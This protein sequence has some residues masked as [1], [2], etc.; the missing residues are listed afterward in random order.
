ML[1]AMRENASSWIIKILLLAIVVAFVFMGLGSYEAQRASKIATVNEQA[2]SVDDYRETYNNLLQ[3]ARQQF[4]GNLNDE[5]LEMM[6]LKQQAMDQLIIRTLILQEAEK[7]DLFVSDEELTGTIQDMPFFKQEDSFNVAVYEKMLKRVGLSPEQFEKDQRSQM[8]AQKLQQFITGS[9]HVSEAEA[10]EWYDWENAL[11]NIRM[12]RFDPET[13]TD[14]K[15]TE[16]EISAYFNENKNSYQTEPKVKAK[17]LRFSPEKYTKDIQVSKDEVQEYYENNLTAYSVEKTVEARHILIKLD[18]NAPEEL[19]QEAKTEAE[20]IAKEAR[21]GKTEFSELAKKYSQDPG[22]DNGGYL[23]KF[24]KNAMVQPF[25]DKA[26]SMNP[27]EISDPVKTRFGWHIIKVENVFPASTRTLAEVEAEIRQSLMEEK[28]RNIAYDEAESFFDAVMEGDD[29]SIEAGSRDLEVTETDFFTRQQ[30]PVGVGDP[31]KFASAAFELPEKETSDILELEGSYYLLQVTGK[32]P[33]QI[34]EFQTVS[35]KVKNDLVQQLKSRKAAEEAEAFLK[36]INTDN[37]LADL[38]ARKNVI[39]TGFFKRNG[40]VPQV[41]YE[42]PLMDAAFLLSG[43]KKWP[44]KVIKGKTNYYV[45]EFI[46]RKKPD[47]EEYQKEKETV[48]NRLSQSKRRITFDAWLT[49]VR[50]ASDI[51]IEES[52]R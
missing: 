48:I 41:G 4:G 49:K 18:E 16:E 50:A 10:R 39:T 8:L 29:L 28:A 30:G 15:P 40:E 46:D 32:I 25:S 14:I 34:A 2:V 20:R 47:P 42:K 3:K 7:L 17:Y 35:E 5:I 38:G 52:F 27:G 24:V 26:F 21:D 51:T 37:S 19:V 44:E 43:E 13:Y 36:S 23:G 12:V 6:N 9:I 31:V 45:I 11:V 1:Q 33:Q 22:R